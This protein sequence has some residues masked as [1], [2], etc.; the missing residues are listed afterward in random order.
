MDLDGLRK[1]EITFWTAWRDGR[2]AGCCA[3]K[4]LDAAHGE[5]KT[6]RVATDLRGKG[7]GSAL[8]HHVIAEAT[9]RGYARLSLETGAMR[10]FAPA[11]RVFLS[12]GFNVCGPFAEYK[13]DPNSVLMTLEL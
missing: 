5:V 4:Q 1:P 13:P 8:V 11:Q 3:L 9:V 6:M 10:F 12:H 7:I 2:L